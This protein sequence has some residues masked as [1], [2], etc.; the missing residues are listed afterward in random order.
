[1]LL[2]GL[3]PSISRRAASAA[4]PLRFDILVSLYFL[5]NDFVFSGVVLLTSN[6][7]RKGLVGSLF[8]SCLIGKK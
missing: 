3:N 7:F 5:L 6:F 1:M 4:G 8:F 2:R